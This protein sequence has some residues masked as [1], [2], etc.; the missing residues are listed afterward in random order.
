MHANQRLPLSGREWRLWRVHPKHAAVS[1]ARAYADADNF[2]VV[3]VNVNDYDDDDDSGPDNGTADAGATD[4]SA[5]TA[6]DAAA[7]SVWM[8]AVVG[9]RRVAAAS[10]RQLFAVG[11][12]GHGRERKLCH[13][14]RLVVAAGDLCRLCDVSV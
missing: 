8:S 14:Q 10:A 1:N 13:Q 11:R 2:H 4:A 6:A 9:R 3:H 5:Y 12:S 7:V